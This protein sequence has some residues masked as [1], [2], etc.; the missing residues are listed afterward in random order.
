[1]TTITKIT[2]DNGSFMVRVYVNEEEMAKGTVIDIWESH[3]I[4]VDDATLKYLA[5]S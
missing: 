2:K 4:I 1:M 5:E 3:Q